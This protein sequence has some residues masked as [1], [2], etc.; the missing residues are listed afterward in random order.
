MADVTTYRDLI[1]WQKAFGLARL[2][3]QMTSTFPPTELYGLTAQIR[4]GA[5]AVASNIAEGYGRGSTL[6]YLRFLKVARGCLF[7]L[8]TQVLL[9]RELS[10]VCEPEYA[11]VNA[12]L[13]ET[14]RVLA[15]LFRSLEAHN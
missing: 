9:A 14:M 2:L 11:D 1:A 4:R 7:E 6:D 10:Y 12:A 3:Y 5:V 8:D 15:G 13:L